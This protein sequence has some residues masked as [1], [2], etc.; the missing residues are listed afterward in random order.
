[1]LNVYEMGRGI[2]MHNMEGKFKIFI[3]EKLQEKVKK[4]FERFQKNFV[5]VESVFE[6]WLTTR[7]LLISV[8]NEMI[9]RKHKKAFKFQIKL[10]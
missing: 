6:V 8:C 9:E 3:L 5:T 10:C 7:K 2:F 4:K 1:M